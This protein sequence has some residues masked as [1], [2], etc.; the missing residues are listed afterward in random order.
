MVEYTLKKNSRSKKV[1]ITVRIDGTVFV[2]VPTRVPKYV[3]KNFVDAQSAWILNTQE[4]FKNERIENDKIGA[5]RAQ[6]STERKKEYEKRKEEARVI[7]KE[8]VETLNI[9]YRFRYGT[10]R[11][12]NQKTRWGSCS[13][14]GNLNFNYKVA[15]LPAPLR[16]YVIIH[17]LCHLKEFNHSKKFWDLVLIGSPQYKKIRNE[18]KNLGTVLS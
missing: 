14:Q 9:Q 16:D 10:I 7:L 18:M 11:I 3:A 12:R 17:E 4:K 13:K 1:R 8:R 2:T 15:F 5:P 6:T